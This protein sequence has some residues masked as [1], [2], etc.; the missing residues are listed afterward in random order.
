MT[1]ISGAG[2]GRIREWYSNI[3][4]DETKEKLDRNIMGFERSILSKCEPWSEWSVQIEP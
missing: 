2:S 1:N 4:S 3:F